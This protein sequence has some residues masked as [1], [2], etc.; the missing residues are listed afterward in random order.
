MWVINCTIYF[1]HFCH[2]CNRKWQ[3]NKHICYH[4][5][6]DSIVLPHSA[7]SVNLISVSLFIMQFPQRK[8]PLVSVT[9]ATPAS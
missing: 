2:I 4:D 1:S 3:S 8:E 6:V 7:I 9:L 5:C